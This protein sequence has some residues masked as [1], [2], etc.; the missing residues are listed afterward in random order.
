MDYESGSSPRASWSWSP[1]QPPLMGAGGGAR[2]LLLYLAWV[3]WEPSSLADESLL[4]ASSQGF[5]HF[6][7]SLC[8]SSWKGTS[9]SSAQEGILKN[10]TVPSV[11]FDSPGNSPREVWYQVKSESGFEAGSSSVKSGSFPRSFFCHV[12]KNH[13]VEKAWAF[14]LARGLICGLC[15]CDPGQVIKLFRASDSLS[16]EWGKCYLPP[17]EC[18]HSMGK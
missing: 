6:V 18:E 8:A 4:F 9:E 10:R 2:Q 15:E 13:G 5:W 17:R 14:G 7:P 3:G 16:L 11:L 1:G 12:G